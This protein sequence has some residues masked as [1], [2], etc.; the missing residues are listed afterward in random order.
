MPVGVKE[1]IDMVVD[2]S[3]F[4]KTKAVWK[5]KFYH[6]ADHVTEQN[7]NLELNP[8]KDY[9]NIYQVIQAKILGVNNQEIA[10]IL[11]DTVSN[12]IFK[13][14]GISYRAV[15]AKIGKKTTYVTDGKSRGFQFCEWNSLES[16]TIPDARSTY[17]RAFENSKRIFLKYD[18]SLKDYYKV[19][20]KI[21]I[22]EEN[23]DE[24]LDKKVFKEQRKKK[25]QK[26]RYRK[27]IR[28]FKNK[29]KPN[30]NIQCNNIPLYGAFVPVKILEA[31]SMVLSYPDGNKHGAFVP[32]STTEFKCR[33]FNEL[34]PKEIKAIKARCERSIFVINGSY[35]IPV[36]TVKGSRVYNAVTNLKRELRTELR[37]DGKK[38]VE[39]DIANSQPLLATILI[40]EYWMNKK[41]GLPSDVKQYQTDCESGQFYNNFMNVIG[42][43]DDL[44]SYFKANFFALVFFGEVTTWENILKDMFIEKY[45]NCWEAICTLKGEP[46][47]DEYKK[48][49]K[50]LQKKE[51]EIIFDQVNMVL[52]KQ[53]ILAFNIF[54]S[55]YVNNRKD[56]EIAKQLTMEAFKYYGLTPTLTIK[57]EEHLIE[58]EH[59]DPCKTTE[60]ASAQDDLE[61]IRS[62]I[63]DN[64][65]TTIPHTPNTKLQHL[66]TGRDSIWTEHTK[67]NPKSDVPKESIQPQMTMTNKQIY[68]F[69][70]Q[71][72]KIGEF[73]VNK[74]NV[75]Y[76]TS[77]VKT[78]LS[79]DRPELDDKPHTPYKYVNPYTA[80]KEKK[81]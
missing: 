72:L 51:A 69:V 80:S 75:D 9:V 13:C 67:T 60:I 41:G 54:D 8:E 57:Y 61:E 31:F 70:V 14:D 12:G 35:L 55:V 58:N 4:Y 23:I 48:F 34:A 64:E 46:G 52:I 47:T 43:P 39:L 32:C 65:N 27:L 59:M 56:F 26:E 18:T 50:M 45:P 49:A 44:R 73:K 62:L 17:K 2:K 79:N 40:K 15:T 66:K 24:I 78:E 22:D 5:Q 74:E 6:L 1:K 30:N 42:V 71:E 7:I 25:S 68:D 10:T 36:R 28:N 20:S 11:R 29:L 81:G 21:R 38:I 63:L 53:G 76:L 33:R 19:L 37:L 16:M 3:S 77:I